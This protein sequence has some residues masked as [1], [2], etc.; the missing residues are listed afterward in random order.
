[1]SGE[2]RGPTAALA[3]T[4]LA[5]LSKPYA[6]AV[7]ARNRAFD[8]GKRNVVLLD[9][10]VI[11]IG[12]ITAGG[13]GK[14]PMCIWL[15]EQLIEMG[16]R[17]AIVS[18]GYGSAKGEAGDEMQV[19]S[20]RVP[21]AV[22][23]ANPHRAAAAE[24]AI[25]EHGAE[26]IVL[27]DGFQHRGLARDLD[28]ALID[29]TYPFGFDHLLPRGL[30][31]EPVENLSRADLF[32]ITRADL[33]G[34]TALLAVLRRLRNISDRTP[35][36]RSRHR[37]TGFAS[38]DGDVSV[39]PADNPRKVFLTAGIGNPRA[40]AD[41]VVAAGFQVVGACWW[42]DHHR[43]STRNAEFVLRRA[44]SLGAEA[45]FTTE[46]D[47]V[48]LRH[49]NVDWRPPVYAVIAEIEFFDRDANIVIDRVRQTLEEFT[50]GRSAD[51]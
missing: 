9:R 8:K 20:H 6:A 21:R 3:R 22:C 1:M 43:F 41:A 37:R 34:A 12:N 7:N 19:I 18:R 25:E 28:I 23:V 45:I 30:L 42:P 48:K 31:R 10:P 47:L 2:K 39:E 26:V 11:S 49:L 16:R 36:A 29:A 24:F 27:D 15:A 46:K 13:T 4:V 40:F 35:I 51:S 33:V 32:I 5:A 17:P 50:A 14:T 38:L 44:R